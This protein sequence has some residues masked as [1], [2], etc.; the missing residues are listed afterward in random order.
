MN[1]L[2]LQARPYSFSTIHQAA[3]GAIDV[4]NRIGAGV[5]F[6]F[7]GILV[8][9]FPGASRAAVCERYFANAEAKND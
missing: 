3:D 5:E 8:T 1:H 9:V 6:E 2:I 7:N 4:A